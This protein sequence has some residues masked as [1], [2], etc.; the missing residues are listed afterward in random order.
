MSEVLKALEKFRDEVVKEAKAELKR[1]NKNSSGKLAESI[2]G[3]VKEF[4]QK[5]NA[6]VSEL[7]KGNTRKG[8]MTKKDYEKIAD[9][10]ARLASYEGTDKVTLE[11]VVIELGQI[12]QADNPRFNFSRFYKACG[13]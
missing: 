12:M 6:V 1:Q 8:N 10:L 2:Q 5:N 11:V 7:G 4:Q 13:F 3:E 9:T